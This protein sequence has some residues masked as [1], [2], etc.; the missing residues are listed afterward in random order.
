MS[1]DFFRARE[2]EKWQAPFSREDF[3]DVTPSL[4]RCRGSRRVKHK[5]LSFHRHLAP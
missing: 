2:Q 1:P 5:A 3:A 4:R